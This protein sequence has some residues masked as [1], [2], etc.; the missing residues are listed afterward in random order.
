MR[1]SVYFH[2]SLQL[3]SG[4]KKDKLLVQLNTPANEEPCL[5]AL[6]TSQQ[7]NRP[8]T[9]GC[10]PRLSLLY[11]EAQKPF[12]DKNTW[13]QLDEIFPF[14]IPTMIK[15]GMQN[16]L[17]EMGVLPK[18]K[19]NEIANCCKRSDDV[20]EYNLQLIWTSKEA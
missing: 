1:G 7:K 4:T 9:P 6:T 10:I 14:D 17:K 5:L 19:M 8:Q 16:D 18:Q 12:F 11:I 15:A 2:K 20:T 13:I 3:S